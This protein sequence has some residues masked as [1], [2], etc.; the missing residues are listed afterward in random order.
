MNFDPASD[1]DNDPVNLGSIFEGREEISHRE[2]GDGF[3]MARMTYFRM[4]RTANN[5]AAMG[6]EPAILAHLPAGQSGCILTLFGRR[7]MFEIVV[8]VRRSD[9]AVQAVA[10]PLGGL[11]AVIPL[12]TDYDTEAGWSCVLRAICAAEDVGFYDSHWAEEA[13]NQ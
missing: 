12:H 3:G 4:A 13:E 9:T 10:H 1:A 7:H 6:V 5:L 11:K 2:R 8:R